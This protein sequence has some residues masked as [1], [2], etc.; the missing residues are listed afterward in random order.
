MRIPIIF[1]V[2]FLLIIR[3]DAQKESRTI[4]EFSGMVFTEGEDGGP[5]PL[6]YTTVAVKGS[7]RGAYSDLDGYFAFIAL[8]GETVVFSRIGYKSVEIVVPDTLSSNHYKWLQIMSSDDYLLPEVFIYPWPSKEHFKQEFFALDISNEIREK[9]QENLAE[10][11]MK[12]M[13]H[14]THPDG[15]EA[16]VL[17]CVNRLQNTFIPDKLNPRIYSVH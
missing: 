3:V 15:K 13:R 7:S 2:F 1:I 4:V 11:A 10:D 6:P 8:A 5:V 16:G 14:S 17:F 9:A 12:E